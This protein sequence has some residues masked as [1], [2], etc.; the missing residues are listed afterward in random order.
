MPA[1]KLAV[2]GGFAQVLQLPY[3]VNVRSLKPWVKKKTP[4][5]PLN[6]SELREHRRLLRKHVRIYRIDSATP[7]ST[8]TERRLAL[9]KI[10]NAAAKFLEPNSRKRLWAE[11]LLDY[12]IESDV[13]T[14]RLLYLYVSTHGHGPDGVIAMKKQLREL[15]SPSIYPHESRPPSGAISEAARDRLLAFMSTG[16]PVVRV[17]ADVNIEA[18]IPSSG[19]WPDPALANLV[20]RVEPIWRRVTGR[21]SGPISK[22]RTGDK[23]CPFAEWLVELLDRAKMGRPSTGRIVDVVRPRQ[24]KKT[25]KSTTRHSTGTGR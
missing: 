21:T 19:R 2:A 15:F 16:L 9:K 13:N 1:G 7:R 6:V 14:N 3:S 25:K 8:A 18:L 24:R 4:P 12:L 10:K 20:A 22:D 5:P 11:R 17:L 23:G